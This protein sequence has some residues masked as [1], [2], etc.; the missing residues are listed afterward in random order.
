MTKHP[1]T[2]A[3]IA[4]NWPDMDSE[5]GRAEIRRQFDA[6]SVDLKSTADQP[7]KYIAIP[8]VLTDAE[9]AIVR[10][11]GSVWN[12]FLALRNRSPE[13]SVEFCHGVHG[14]QHAVMARA[15]QRAHP[16]VFR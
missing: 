16:E 15:A 9:L 8:G 5:T 14:L 10:K 11:L 13:A 4:E 12:D 6:I 3:M 7:S 1:L 2:D